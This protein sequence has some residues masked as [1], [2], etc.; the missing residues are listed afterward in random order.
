MPVGP[1]DVSDDGICAVKNYVAGGGGIEHKTSA[2]IP[3]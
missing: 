3:Y 2:L 1:A